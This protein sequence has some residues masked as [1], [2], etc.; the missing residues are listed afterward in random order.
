M[1][2]TVGLKRSVPLRALAMRLKREP[3]RRLRDRLQAV[4]WAAA[5]VSFQDIAQRIGRCRQSVSSFVGRFNREGLGG[6][7][8]VGRGPGRRSRLSAGQWE[9]VVEWVRTGPRSLGHPFS[10]WD[11][12]RLAAC[13][14]RRWRVRLSDEQVRRQLHKQGCRLLRPTH[15][16]PGRNPRDRAKKNGPWRSCWIAPGITGA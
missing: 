10:N 8:R 1:P 3:N 7:L 13:I 5:G 14:Q 15:E 6:L 9:Q 16:L 12:R 2:R 11:C 4:Q